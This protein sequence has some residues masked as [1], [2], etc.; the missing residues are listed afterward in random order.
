MESEKTLKWLKKFFTILD[1]EE[2]VDDETL[3]IFEDIILGK[4][5]K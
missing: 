5:V 3:K 4:E 1:Q 2:I